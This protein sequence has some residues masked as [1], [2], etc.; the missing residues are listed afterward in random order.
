MT[1]PLF[2]RNYR[3]HKTWFTA[4]AHDP[5]RI[6]VRFYGRGTV[7]GTHAF[8]A[9]I[10]EAITEFP[11]ALPKSALLDVSDLRKTPLR[12]QIIMGHWLLTKKQLIGHVALVGA[13]AWERT[14]AKA[15]MK[16]ARMNRIDF[17]K[18]E[19]AAIR[20]LDGRESKTR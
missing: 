15:V 18:T 14:I 13:R 10:D 4:E 17:F 8:L 7:P 9:V 5:Y 3:D 12:S 6:V 1:E 19:D 2:Q 11:D 16:L 20:W